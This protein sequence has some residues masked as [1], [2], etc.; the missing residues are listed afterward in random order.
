MG[1]SFSMGM[2]E[3]DACDCAQGT[4]EAQKEGE[5]Y[6]RTSEP[7][8]WL[9]FLKIKMGSGNLKRRLKITQANEWHFTKGN[10]AG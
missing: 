5:N 10:Y 4:P 8:K 1:R 9:L 7:L 2:M 6:E 3:H